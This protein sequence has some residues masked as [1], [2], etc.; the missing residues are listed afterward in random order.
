MSARGRRVRVLIVD[1]EPLAREHLATL[2]ADESEVEVVGEAGGGSEAVR[3]IRSLKPDA[4]FLDVQ[5]P[6]LDGF[7]VIR[8]IPLDQ[9][10]L[11]VFVTAYDEHAL[12]AFDVAAVDYLLKPVLDDRFR[13]AVRRTVERALAP[14]ASDALVR[15]SALADALS[16]S[17]SDR[18][19]LT[20]DGRVLFLSPR[21]IDW[22]DAADDHVR[23]HAGKA[24]H[25]VRETMASVEARLGAGFVRIHR[26]TL[27]NSRRIREIQPWV[28]GDYVLILHDGTRLTSGRTYRDQVRALLR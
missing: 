16:A 14:R 27:V 6:G 23:V 13:V 2:L 5:M 8:A 21:E 28:K 3:L 4:V 20:V 1:D 19:P 12:S 17:G 10:P 24:V 15:L 22:I 9:L 11:V 7:A 25:A 18:I 26:S